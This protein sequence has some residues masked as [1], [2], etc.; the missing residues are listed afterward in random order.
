MKL[1]SFKSSY[2]WST[3][4]YEVSSPIGNVK[5]EVRKGPV[6]FRMAEA[7]LRRVKSNCEHQAC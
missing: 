2:E 1:Q 4:S 7:K 6:K 5:G 3:R